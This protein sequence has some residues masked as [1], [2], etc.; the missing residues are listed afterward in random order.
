M[1]NSER[2]THGIPVHTGARQ[3]VCIE[4]IKAVAEFTNDFILKI[5]NKSVSCKTNKMFIERTFCHVVHL[6]SNIYNVCK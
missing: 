4:L 1:L 5:T 2:C 3:V 6:S